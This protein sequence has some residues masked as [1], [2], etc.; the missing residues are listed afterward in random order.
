M[1]RFHSLRV[2]EVRPEAEAAVRLALQVPPELRDEYRMRPGQHVVLRVQLDGEEVRRTYSLIGTPDDANLEIA[3]RVHSRGRLSRHLAQRVRAGDTLDVLPP[4]GSFGPR[5]AQPRGTY[6]A[7][8]SGCGITP[9]IAI[10]RSLLAADPGNRV[11]IFYG[12]RSGARTM[13]MEEL[14]ALKDRHLGQL[15]LF[16]LMTR[17]PQD[18]DLFNGRVDA[19]KLRELAGRLFEPTA[20]REY[21]ICGP[22][23]M[24][25]D[26]GAQLRALGVEPGRIHGERFT[27]AAPAP[28]VEA[29]VV[30]VPQEE[31][32]VTQVAVVM[33]GRRRVFPMRGGETILD[34]AARAS[35]DLPFSC[36]AGVCSTCRTKLVR[37]EVEMQQN[38]A[39]EEWEV[40]QG[41]ILACQSHAKTP[42]L[43]INYDER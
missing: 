23:P 8:A 20:I 9:V 28:A 18:V 27:V 41:F 14:L 24:I 6:V 13:L 30:A 5:D 31:A 15:S 43:E 32:G 25:D 1:L 2:A 40:E 3:V 22:D 12:N 29:P 7:F 37:G 10:V 17:E 16:F 34:A 21:F 36:R 38:Y 39:L 35:L 26:I 33:D 42:E 11:L 4:N 19:G